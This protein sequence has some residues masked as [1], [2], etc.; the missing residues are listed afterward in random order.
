MM[1]DAVVGDLLLQR[2][3]SGN[4][5]SESGCD[6]DRSLAS[7][8]EREGHALLYLQIFG[9]ESRIEVRWESSVVIFRLPLFQQFYSRGTKKT[10]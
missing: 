9:H 4:F 5:V 6:N 2:H 10:D 7:E 3:C 8:V 1:L